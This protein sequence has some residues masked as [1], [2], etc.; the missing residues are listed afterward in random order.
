MMKRIVTIRDLAD[1]TAAKRDL[2]YWMGRP[3]EERLAAV[4]TLRELF[5]GSTPRLQRIARVVQQT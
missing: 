3:H 2:V 5:Y 1:S 4:D